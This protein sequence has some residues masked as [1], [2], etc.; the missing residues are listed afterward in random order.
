MAEHARF[1]YN[2]LEDLQQHC[3][4]IGVD[5]PFSDNLS[6]LAEPV[7][8]GN[9]LLPNRLT[10]HP[11]EGCDGE[12]DGRPGELTRRRYRRFAA[13]GAGLIWL[14]ACAVVPEG[15][16]NPRQLWLHEANLAEFAQ[17]Q[18][19]MLA[20]AREEMGTSHRPMLILQL[21][22]S[23][24]YSKP[25]GRPAPIIAHHSPLDASSHVDA[26]THM[27]N[28]EE[29][30]QLLD[31]YVAAA[32]LAARA[33]FDGVDIKSC[34]RYLLS[35]LLASFTRD[36][37]RYGGEY[38]NRVRFLLEAIRRIRSEVPELTVC[39]R[40]NIYDAMEYPYGWGVDKDNATQPD[41]AEPSQLIAELAQAGLAAVNVT[42]G[43][44]YFR[45]HFNRP[46]DRPV[47]GGYTPNE[48]PL[49]SISRFIK[50]TGELQQAHP[51]THIVGSGYSW[52]RQFFPYIAAGAISGKL[53]TS[54]GL[55]REAFAYP[56][57]ARDLLQDGKLAK[58]KL[59][60]A[61]SSCTQ[62][63]R[64]GVAS[65]CPVRDAEVYRPIYQHGREAQAAAEGKY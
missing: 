40:L 25:Q 60:I 22:H 5:I 32:K 54:V 23:G 28:D 21:T 14:E 8:L 18:E 16:A 52:L 51:Q 53:V 29:L 7:A 24:R 2:C 57:F 58:E 19:M 45:P 12:V 63:M 49:E 36:N 34:H 31:A 41:L 17:L 1:T 3:Q 46:Y 42:L 48:H 6:L 10:I 35:E 64:D 43:N 56:N 9:F 15:R 27:I 4:T 47:E 33:G 37:S 62:M 44:P 30:D 11:M 13:G 38:N 39:S 59:C 55:G 50:L 65:G 20:T 26:D 61:C